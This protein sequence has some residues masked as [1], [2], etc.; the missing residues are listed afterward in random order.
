[1]NNQYY[2]VNKKILPE[3]IDEVIKIKEEIEEEGLS[4]STACEKHNLSRST[5][6]KY[7]DYVFKP[8]QNT[9]SKAIIS[10]RALNVKGVLST[11][12]SQVAS[13]NANIITLNQDMPIKDYAF[14]T[15]TIDVSKISV[16]L[17]ELID[18]LKQL[19]NVKKVELIA[20]EG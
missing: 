20:F 1:M 6:Y 16:G 8:I 12:L 17:D 11:V 15:L 19:E 2:L 4:V 7:R 18:K 9:A 3:F 13:V 10:F 14:I 5:Y